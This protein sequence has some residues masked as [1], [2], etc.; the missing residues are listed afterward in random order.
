MI[1]FV[2]FSLFILS[3]T[4]AVAAQSG[5]KITTPEPTPAPQVK[6]ENADFSE[7]KPL[8]KRSVTP[9]PS[10]KNASKNET[11]T[12]TQTKTNEAEVLSDSEDE[13]VKIE[14]NLITIPVSVFDRNGLYI[15]NL[16]KDNFQIFED[17]VEQQIEFFATTENPFTVVL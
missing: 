11:K 3:F 9:F 16:Y 15:P 17:G 13:A 10:L 6:D 7:S 8:P 12:Q 5:R 2:I 1:R 14:T 4:V